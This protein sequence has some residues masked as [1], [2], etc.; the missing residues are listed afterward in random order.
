MPVPICHAHLVIISLITITIL[1]DSPNY[2][3][4]RM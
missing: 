3:A 2:E 4:P 1:G